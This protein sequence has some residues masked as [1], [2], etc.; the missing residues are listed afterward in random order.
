MARY[1]LPTNSKYQSCNKKS[2]S[3]IVKMLRCDSY[4]DM[5]CSDSSPEGNPG[6]DGSSDVSAWPPGC[7][8]TPDTWCTGMAWRRRASAGVL[9]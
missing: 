4:I 7:Y 6:W 9:S 5:C 1:I 8:R 3:N 2:S